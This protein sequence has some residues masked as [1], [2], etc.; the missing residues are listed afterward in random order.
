VEVKPLDDGSRKDL[1]LLFPEIKPL[2][3]CDISLTKKKLKHDEVKICERLIAK[4]G[5]GPEA[6]GKMFKDIKLNYL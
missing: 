6:H 1:T 5:E 3:E 2:E 4:Y